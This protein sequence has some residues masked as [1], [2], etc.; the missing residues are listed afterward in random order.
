MQKSSSS[1]LI[2]SNSP[3][4]VKLQVSQQPK[5]QS[6]D[7]SPYT[8]QMLQMVEKTYQPR[9][10]NE[11]HARQIVPARHIF[12]SQ[13]SISKDESYGQSEKADKTRNRF[14]SMIEK[15]EADQTK[16]LQIGLPEGTNLC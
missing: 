16:S 13:K 1:Y 3:Y 10:Q 11:E 12:K 5:L 7:R 4:N 14:P 6:M 9:I 15:R 2:M 8:V